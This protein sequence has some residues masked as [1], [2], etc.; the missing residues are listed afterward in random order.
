M[1]DVTSSYGMFL[2]YIEFYF[3]YFSHIIKNRSHYDRPKILR[4]NFQEGEIERPKR[5]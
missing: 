5:S 3:K 1:S 2:D 4:S